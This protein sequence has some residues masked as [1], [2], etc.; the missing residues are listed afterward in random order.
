M[1]E[2][3]SLTSI[4]GDLDVQYASTLSRLVDVDY[5]QA[6]SDLTQ[7]QTYL[8]ASQQSHLRVTGLS[9]FDHLS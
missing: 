7:Q 3:D 9:L 8:Q 4:S 2:L 1:V 6:I 5:A